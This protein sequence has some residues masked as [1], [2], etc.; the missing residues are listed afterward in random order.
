MMSDNTIISIVVLTYNARWEKLS[1]TLMSIITQ[2]NIKPQIVV[3][4]DGSK[5]NLEN[6]ILNLF[7]KYN[8]TNYKLSFQS[9]NRGTVDNICRALQLCDGKYIKAISP[10]DYF[11]D[12]DS[13]FKWVNFMEEKKSKI[14]FGDAVFY[15]HNDN[16]IRTIDNISFPLCKD[17]Y[18]ANKRKELFVRYILANDT[19]LGASL[20]FNKE[21]LIY[22]MDKIKGS[23]KYAEDF[24]VRIAVFE[25]IR[26]DYYSKFI[27][28]YEYGTGI[29]SSNNEKWNKRILEDFNSSNI[30]IMN[31][32]VT[33]DNLSE[34]YKAY[35]W[36]STNWPKALTK[37]IKVFYFPYL[38]KIRCEMRYRMKHKT[39]TENKT[40]STKFI[41]QILMKVE[42]SNASN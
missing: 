29:S 16:G 28:W 17:V 11:Y 37:L 3:A 20:A 19:I 23:I 4:D 35:L 13:L 33:P 8:F 26:I 22:L 12:S 6:D 32:E 21:T 25:N 27:I 42:E 38:I 24:A 5:N 41:K 34:R 18:I 40:I 14:S 1:T 7:T 10:G 2:I 36:K 15:C 39:E 9:E 30:I 31:D